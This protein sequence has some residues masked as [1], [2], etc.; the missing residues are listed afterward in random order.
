[1]PA[2]IHM[3]IEYFVLVSLIG[4]NIFSNIYTFKNVYTFYV[5]NIETVTLSRLL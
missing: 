3:V 1:M 2:A 5:E 4:R